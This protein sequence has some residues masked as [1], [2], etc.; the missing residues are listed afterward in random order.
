M[1]LPALVISSIVLL[2][3]LRP[4]YEIWFR[5]EKYVARINAQRDSAK[6]LLGFSLTRNRG[7]K[8]LQVKVLS[9]LLII[10]CVIG[11]IFSITGP[12][13]Y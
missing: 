7:V 13:R 2:M 10:F 8:M 5:P 9:I 12:I 4:A 6:M 1:N 3:S 11:I